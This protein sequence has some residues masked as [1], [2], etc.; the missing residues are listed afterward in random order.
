MGTAE[1]ARELCGALATEL[2]TPTHYDQHRLCKRWGRGA[3]AMDT[4]IEK[5]HGAG[6][7]ASRTH[8]SGTSFKTDADVE[9]IREATTE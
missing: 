9:E 1:K 7:E 6:Y 2:D 5:L 3:E 8:Y 4:F